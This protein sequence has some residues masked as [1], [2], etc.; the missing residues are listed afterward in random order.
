MSISVEANALRLEQER[1]ANRVR[2]AIRDIRIELDRL[3]QD[4]SESGRARQAASQASELI[5]ASA[6]LETL[7]QWGNVFAPEV[8]TS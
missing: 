5:Q 1:T 8:S 3:E 4:P 2:A 6:K 7:R